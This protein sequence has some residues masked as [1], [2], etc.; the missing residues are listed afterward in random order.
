MK[1]DY[2]EFLR[3][4]L[5]KILEL[6]FIENCRREWYKLNIRIP[7]GSCQFLQVTYMTQNSNRTQNWHKAQ[8]G[9]DIGPKA[10]NMYNKN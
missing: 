8:Y 7:T 5:E 4:I 10:E 1:N 2:V 3:K 9:H 6:F